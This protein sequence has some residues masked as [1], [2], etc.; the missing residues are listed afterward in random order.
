MDLKKLIE[1]GR[2]ELVYT[3]TGVG[4][5]HFTLPPSSEIKTGEDPYVLMAKHIT[6]IGDDDYTSEAKKAE[7]VEALKQMGPSIVAK[8]SKI[9]EEALE[10]QSKAAEGLFRKN[11]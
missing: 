11:S 2:V 1:V 5:M 9:C 8:I 4:E 7:L 6:R 3:V 10:E